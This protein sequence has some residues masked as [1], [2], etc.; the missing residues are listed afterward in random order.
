MIISLGTFP[1]LAGSAAKGCW[2][3]GG[4]VLSMLSKTPVSDFDLYPKTK[5]DSDSTI[6]DLLSDGYLESYSK[7]ALTFK[8]NSHT[9]ADKRLNPEQRRSIFQVMAMEHCQ[10]VEEIFDAFDFTICM[11][12]QDGDTGEVFIHKDFTAD[13]ASKTLRFHPGTRYPLASLRRVIKYQKKGYSISSAQMARIA[14]TCSRQIER[15][16]DWS[17]LSMAMGGF[18]GK[19]FEFDTKDRTF[20]TETAIDLL[21]E[22]DQQPRTFQEFVRFKDEGLVIALSNPEPIFIE[23]GA[24]SIRPLYYDSDMDEWFASDDYVIDS[25]DCIFPHNFVRVPSSAQMIVQIRG[26]IVDGK[27][28]CPQHEGQEKHTFRTN[29]VEA[30]RMSMFKSGFRF[31]LRNVSWIGSSSTNSKTPLFSFCMRDNIEKLIDSATKS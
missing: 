29:L 3:A 13:V 15:M 1:V 18:Y 12:V 17:D 27:F 19:R 11:A 28:F 5:K 25:K 8:S 7:L 30:I 2:V 6:V 4:S 20:E 31:E 22:W 9:L 14:L 24:T 16:R 23:D 21:S 10:T 26:E